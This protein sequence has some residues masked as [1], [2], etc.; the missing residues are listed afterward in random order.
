MEDWK[1][2]MVL[3]ANHGIDAFALNFGRDDWQ[4]Q[5]LD[6][7]YAAAL[8]LS[9]GPWGL[10]DNTAN[11]TTPTDTPS[12]EGGNAC[13]NSTAPCISVEAGLVSTNAFS[14]ATV[15]DS[16]AHSCTAKPIPFKL[17]LSLDMSSLPCASDADVAALQALV[18]RYAAH[19]AQL[20]HNGTGRAVLS[21]FAGDAC[22]FGQAGWARVAKG[23]GAWF[24]PAFFGDVRSWAG[25]DA[26]NGGFN[27]NAA[28]PTGKFNVTWD[29]DAAW[30]SAL[31]VSGKQKAYMA[32]VSPWFFTHFG[33]NTYNKNWIYRGDEWLLAARWDILIAHR[34]QVDIVQIVSWNDYGES[35]YVGPI[36]GALP[37]G[38]EAWTN[39]FE[40]TAWLKMM[41][42]YIAAFKT[43][44][45]PD[46][47]EDHVFLWARLDPA[48][49]NASKDGVGK[50]RNWEW[51]EDYLWAVIFLTAPANVTL[52]CTPGPTQNETQLL[53]QGVSQVKLALIDPGADVSADGRCAMGAEIWRAETKVLAFQ[54]EGMRFGSRN[55]NEVENYNF[56]AFVAG[57]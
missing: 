44:T 6:D 50:P 43:G 46:V 18:E 36:E 38:S 12:S 52:Y 28:W 22:A 21:T 39:G 19:P 49:A 45:Y 51:T 35:H 57:T 16:D 48:N 4:R 20:L 13:A 40:H 29:P 26:V 47:H 41:E 37:A 17:F 34:D 55:G 14:N 3:A 53:P 30:R 8:E 11:N 42:Y 25:W 54:P 24:V 56:N 31:N 27:W 15:P 32:P 7:A 2:D 1:R 9:H 5:R 23:S 33:Q 10:A